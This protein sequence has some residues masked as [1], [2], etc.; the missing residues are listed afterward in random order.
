MSTASFNHQPRVW[1]KVN[2]TSLFAVPFWEVAN[3]GRRSDSEGFMST[4]NDLQEHGRHPKSLQDSLRHRCCVPRC[5]PRSSG[6]LA[7][8]VDWLRGN[9]LCLGV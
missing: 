6:D 3:R 9:S 8:L 1:L 7:K 5:V 4:C 2:R